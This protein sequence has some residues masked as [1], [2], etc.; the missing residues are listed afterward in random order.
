MLLAGQ[1]AGFVGRLPATALIAKVKQT[2]HLPEPQS[3]KSL[4]SAWNQPLSSK[5]SIKVYIWATRRG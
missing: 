1:H 4:S 5:K 3:K 2:K